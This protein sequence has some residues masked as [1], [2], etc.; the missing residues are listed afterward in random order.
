V[1]TEQ[2]NAANRRSAKPEYGVP[3]R[4]TERSKAELP[5]FHEEVLRN[6]LIVN[7]ESGFPHNEKTTQYKRAPQLE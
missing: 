7:W 2:R 1:Q 6:G 3:R 5:W 4:V